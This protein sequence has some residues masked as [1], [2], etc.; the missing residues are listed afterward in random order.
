MRNTSIPNNATVLSVSQQF[1]GKA[2][3]H[4]LTAAFRNLFREISSKALVNGILPGHLKGV[5]QCGSGFFA[6][7]VTREDSVDET[8]NPQWE[9]M[10]FIENFK[11]TVNLLS[12]F[13][14]DISREELEAA[15]KKLPFSK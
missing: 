4:I 3:R 12:I 8:V 10:D 7:S 2:N 5:I 13:P 1:S 14:V 11:I 9:A 6:L 15:L